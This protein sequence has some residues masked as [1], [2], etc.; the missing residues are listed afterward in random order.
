MFIL[1]IDW[2]M[3]RLATQNHIDT[4]ETPWTTLMTQ[5]SFLQQ[6]TYARKYE[7]IQ[8]N[9]I[10][11]RAVL[12]FSIQDAFFIQNITIFNLSTYWRWIQMTC[13]SEIQPADPWMLTCKSVKSNSPRT[14]RVLLVIR[15]LITLDGIPVPERVK[16]ATHQMIICN[17][18]IILQKSKK[19]I[20][21]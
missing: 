17:F 21:F 4:Q 13:Q 15:L 11:Q 16:I 6:A 10:S 18:Q 8:Q 19:R 3:K 14:T 12:V 7:K 20:Y 2:I 9:C 5:P 1:A